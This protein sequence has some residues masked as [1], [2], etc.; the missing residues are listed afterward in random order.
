MP[1]IIK[2]QDR[3]QKNPKKPENLFKKVKCLVFLGLSEYSLNTVGADGQQ[4]N[5]NS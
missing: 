2:N 3:V 5:R 1:R 4:S